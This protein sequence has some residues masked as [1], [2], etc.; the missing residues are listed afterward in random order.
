MKINAY[1]LAGDPAWTAESVGSYYSFVDRLVVSYDEENLSWSGHELEVPEALRRLTAC[2]PQHKI[3]PL[4]GRYSAPD[5]FALDMETEQRQRALD[6]ASEGADWVVQLDTDE[7]LASPGRFLACLE[8]AEAEGFDAVHFPSRWWYQ[9]AGAGS[10]RVL[11]RRRRFGGARAEYPGAIA[12]R[13]GTRLRH[14]R[15][16]DV[17]HFRVD[18]AATSTDPAHPADAVVHDV[19]TPD[20]GI[21][22]LSWLRSAEQMERKRV[23]SGHAGRVDLGEEIRRWRAAYR[24]PRLTVALGSVHR[25]PDRWLRVVSNPLELRSGDWL[26]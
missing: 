12:V 6:A 8:R 1:V 22:H 25:H 23:V 4:P 24:H 3:V 11:E 7:V 18:F 9:R 15:Q 21:I 17:P 26:P 13:A 19:V 10:D 20:E 14:C 16:T 5:R 2:D